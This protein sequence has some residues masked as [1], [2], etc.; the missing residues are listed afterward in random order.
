MRVKRF[1][2]KSEALTNI[3]AAKWRSFLAIIGITM[4]SAAVVALLSLSEIASRHASEQF[5][6]LGTN[7]IAINLAYPNANHPG[8]MV[9][10]VDLSMVDGLSQ[11]V[12]GLAAVA[13]YLYLFQNSRYRD[14][15]NAGPCLG[16]TESFQDLAHLQLAAGRFIRRIDATSLY[17]VIGADIAASLK[18][19]GLINPL[20]KQIQLGE[21]YVTIIGI[22]EKTPSSLFVYLDI[23]QSILLPLETSYLF[24]ETPAISNLLIRVKN[25]HD[26]KI[27][28][29]NILH[30]L[31]TN[32]N[33][34]EIDLR[35]PEQLLDMLK[36][37]QKTFTG[38]LFAIGLL[39]L[40]VGG[41]GVMN[42]MLMI[43]NERRGEIGVRLAIGALPREILQLFLSE[44]VILSLIGGSLGVSIGEII[45]LLWSYCAKWTF[46]WILFPFIL[47]LLLSL[48]M[49]IF[50]GFYPAWRAS[51]LNP[52]ECLRAEF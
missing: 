1:L 12:Q 42:I 8:A 36:N 5:K 49:G 15:S 20:G 22:L 52:I 44:A 17:A 10:G 40:I 9:M 46:Y 37:Q 30:Y 32:I 14:M 41:V 39:T 43:V 28:E 7:L 38:L 33:D 31:K 35:D 50:F 45:T 51:R 6:T 21:Y 11:S 19:Q 29:E 47:G 18:E 4:G 34:I 2:A 3:L 24:S 25:S 16:V 13:P 23:N 48:F 26:L 27:N